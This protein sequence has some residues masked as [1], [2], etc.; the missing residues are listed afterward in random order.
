MGPSTPRIIHSRTNY[1]GLTLV[2]LYRTALDT[3]NLQETNLIRSPGNIRNRVQRKIQPHD[4]S[5]HRNG[6]HDPQRR[7]PNAH[8][9]AEL[10]VTSA[11]GGT[12]REGN[13]W[14]GQR[15]IPG[16]GRSLALP[17]D[18]A[19]AKSRLYHHDSFLNISPWNGHS[20]DS[21]T[22]PA[23]TGLLIM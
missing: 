23:L 14:D 11:P 12:V 20:S 8:L 3:Q 10:R 21:V 16:I 5:G 22:R 15:D 18:E 13:G 1:G 4:R 6:E 2:R 7:T 19:R 17:Q 9:R